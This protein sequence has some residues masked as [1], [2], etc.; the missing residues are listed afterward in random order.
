M[1]VRWDLRVWKHLPTLKMLLWIGPS[2]TQIKNP[3]ILFVGGNPN[4]LT[5]TL[6]LE[7]SKAKTR[8]TMGVYS[9]FISLDRGRGG[10]ASQVLSS[11]FHNEL[12][13]LA[14]HKKK[15]EA[16]EANQ[17]PSFSW[18]R[19][20]YPLAHLHRWERGELWAKHMG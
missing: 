15:I 9:F 10:C 7:W 17:N 12:F 20:A 14:H 16:L 8:A 3:S 4:F 18:R 5:Y 11:S 6:W 19:N 2:T 1:E 13:W